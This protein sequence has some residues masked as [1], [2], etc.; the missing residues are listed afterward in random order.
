MSNKNQDPFN[1]HRSKLIQF[2]IEPYILLRLN[3][4]AQ[5]HSVSMA[6]K[7]VRHKYNKMILFKN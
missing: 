2:F 3:H 5:M 1:N 6:G 4:K 7:N